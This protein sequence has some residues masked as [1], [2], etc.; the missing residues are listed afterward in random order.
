MQW[1]HGVA[2]FENEN[3]KN[4][5]MNANLTPMQ[6]SSHFHSAIV[7]LPLISLSRHDIDALAIVTI[8]VICL[9]VISDRSIRSIMLDC[10]CNTAVGVGLLLQHSSRSHHNAPDAH[11]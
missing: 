8:M 7:M 9:S 5:Q 3:N 6:G 10:C 2:N 1:H 4:N 11:N